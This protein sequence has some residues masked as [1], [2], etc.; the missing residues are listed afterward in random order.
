MNKS[1][2]RIHTRPIY[3]C[4]C[5]LLTELFVSLLWENLYRFLPRKLN[6]FTIYHFLSKSIFLSFEFMACP[7]ISLSFS[8]LHFYTLHDTLEPEK[9]E[10]KCG[11]PLS[12][13]KKKGC[14]VL[15]IHNVLEFELLP[16]Q[17][18]SPPSPHTRHLLSLLLFLIQWKHFLKSYCPLVESFS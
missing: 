16:E 12:D 9:G 4:F 8:W 5:R 1:P 3:I 2:V 15:N 6:L 11:S 10:A 18:P 7:R 14:N 13:F 17:P